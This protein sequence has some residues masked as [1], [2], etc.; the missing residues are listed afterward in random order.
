MVSPLDD[1]V[2]EGGSVLNRLGEDLQ[3]ISVLIVVQKNLVL[4]ESVDV[5]ADLNRH[6]RQVLPN[7]VIVGIGD[8]QELHSTLGEG[9][10]SVDNSLSPE[11]NVLGS[12]AV[13][14]VYVLLDLRFFLAFSGLVDGHFDVLVVVCDHDGP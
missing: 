2:E 5:L 12:R 9:L 11:R 14:V 1:F 6:I 10:Y 8:S 4:L 13:V 3:Q 7:V